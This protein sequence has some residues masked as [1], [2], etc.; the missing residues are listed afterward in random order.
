MR[1]ADRPAG[2]GRPL[3][4]RRDATTEAEELEETVEDLDPDVPVP[5][6]AGRDARHADRNAHVKPG[7][8]GAGDNAE[9][10]S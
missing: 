6:D 5:E 10:G 7:R 8:D 3:T 9:G 4:E 2:P 1:H